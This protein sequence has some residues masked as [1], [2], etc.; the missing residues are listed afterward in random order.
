MFSSI[1]CRGVVLPRLLAAACVVAALNPVPP[2]AAAKRTLRPPVAAIAIYAPSLRAVSGSIRFAARGF[3]PLVR[4]V[5]FAI[6]GRRVWS[7]TSRPF[8]FDRTG[9]LNTRTL[10]NGRHVLSVEAIY[11]AGRVRVRVARRAIEVGNPTSE[12]RPGRA[13]APG[14]AGTAGSRRP[15]E[16]NGT[17][18]STGPATIG[19][20]GPP[21]IA[22]GGPEVALYNRETYQ[23]SSALTIAQEAARYQVMVLQ[24]TDANLVPT[25]HA[26]NPNL[27]VLVYQDILISK[28]TDPSALTTCTS[29]ADDAA[30][31]PDWFLK[32]QNGS[33]TLDGSY[34]NDYLMDVGNPAYQQACAAHA[35]AISKQFGFDGVFFDDVTAQ[36]SWDLAAGTSVPA[37]PKITAW[38]AA[39]DSMVAHVGPQMHALGLLAFGNIGGAAGT[40]GLW[41]QWA[42]SLDG[43]E[44]ESWGGAG[45]AS[46]Q[47]HD[48]PAK[49]AE[50][51]WSEAN[52]KYVLLHSYL[53]DEAGNTFG[54]ASMMLIANG[55]SSYSTTDASGTEAWYPEFAT[56]QQLGAPAGPYRQL[57]NGVYERVFANGIV[58]VNPTGTPV[59]SFSLGGDQYSGSGLVDVTSISLPATGAAI[60]LRTG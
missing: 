42:A 28:P 45:S 36:L 5:S 47:I 40:P 56:A 38:Q 21:A 31:H 39:M 16:S 13:K 26:A 15:A 1:S 9:I 30:N 59:A 12:P 20:V 24:A 60:L 7:T 25:L 2:D 48:W 46:Q 17:T 14:P 29:Y 32:D 10:R 35:A 23:Y 6:D 3:G 51:A 58:L 27:K 43:A 44:E 11:A 41:Q 33:P 53:S 37:Y 49:L 57:S 52:G 34:A 55:W 54:L 50:A 19:V 18:A 8:L 22:G 4:R